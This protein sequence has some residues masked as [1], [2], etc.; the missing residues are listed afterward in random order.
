MHLRNQNTY[1][2]YNE[3]ILDSVPRLVMSYYWMPA[4]AAY[5][6][7]DSAEELGRGVREL[8]SSMDVYLL[9]EDPEPEVPGCTLQRV[10]WSPFPKWVTTHFNF[11]DW[12]GRSI[13]TRNIFRISPD[14]PAVARQE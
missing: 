9:S 12:A 13:R 6:T 7:F 5:R 11:N 2:C 8:S 1:Y 4:D 3:A 10:A 14:S